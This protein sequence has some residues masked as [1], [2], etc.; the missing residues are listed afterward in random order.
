MIYSFLLVGHAIL[1][2]MY[3]DSI[4]FRI[5]IKRIIESVCNIDCLLVYFHLLQH[6]EIKR[7]SYGLA[8]RELK[9]TFTVCS[10]FRS[11]LADVP[12]GSHSSNA[13]TN[14]HSAICSVACT[15]IA[16]YLTRTYTRASWDSKY[17]L[18]FLRRNANNG[19]FS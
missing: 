4:A 19:T 10:M 11:P 13:D 15:N 5:H 1:K 12:D 3:Q 17:F 8:G 6:G 2:M 9:W 16:Q 14:Q 7:A 18:A